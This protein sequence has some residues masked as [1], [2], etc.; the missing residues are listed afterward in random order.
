ME[1][2]NI[3]EEVDKIDESRIGSLMNELISIDTSVPPGKNYEIFVDTVGP[4]LKN[5]GFS[6]EK[7]VVPSSKLKGI[8]L[9]LEGER[10]NLVAYRDMGKNQDLNFYA[11]MDVV[12]V[13]DKKKWRYDPFVATVT[14][15]G[16]IYGRGTSDMKGTIVCLILAL[17]LLTQLNLES[18]YNIKIL[19]C[20]DE[21]IGSYPG[22]KYL[23][24][25]GYIEK[26]SEFFCMEGAQENVIPIGAAGALN[27]EVE[28]IGISCHSGMNFMGINAIEQSI[29]ILNE[30]M[31]LKKI[32]EKRQSKTIPG[33]PRQDDPTR[34]MMSPMF[35]IDIIH[36]GVKSNIVPD[37]CSFVVNRRFI[38]DENFEDVKN[39]IVEAIEKGRT[40]SSLKNVNTK[41]FKGYPPFRTDPDSKVSKKILK[42]ICKVHGV[43]PEKIRYLGIS[44]STDM[45]FVNQVTSNI[46][47]RG[48][49]NISSNSHGVNES[50]RMRDV[51]SFI[52][53]II[54]YLW[55]DF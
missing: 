4:Y 7:V 10:V 17:E 31:K 9:P 15:R 32:T 34:R 47:M 29:P 5:L 14:K 55:S 51:K 1:I 38:P 54:L 11:H 21:E 16:K 52:K 33:I 20:T 12:P 37:K 22:V 3:F 48:V 23:T 18:K 46:I 25:K 50:I 42:V 36:G 53:E 44:G 13:E 35:N 27:V 41:Y 19:L 24:E 39:E 45:G 2:S 49:A 8:P 6:L 30:L 28:G 40:Q 43:Q 26:N